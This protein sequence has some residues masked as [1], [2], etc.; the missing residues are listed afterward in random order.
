MQDLPGKAIYDFHFTTIRKKLF[1]HDEFGPKVQMPVSYYFRRLK[2][3]PEIEQIAIEKCFGKVLDI[4]AAAGSHSLEIQKKGLEVSAIEI[5]PKA[6]EVMKSRGVN[7]VLCEDFFKFSGEKFDTLL[8][9]MNGIGI[10]ATIEGFWKFLKKAENLLK[11]GGQIVFDSCDVHYMYEEIEIPTSHYYGETKF[12]Y[13]YDKQ[14]TDWFEW[15]YIDQMTMQKI[16]EECG[17]RSEIIFE[18]DSSQYLA[19]LKKFS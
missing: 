2:Q 9:L 5:S 4:G 3:M 1:V 16:A 19:V 11:E 15:L 13:E 12:S 10:S 6:C 17:F 7:R 18:D 14:F 8:L